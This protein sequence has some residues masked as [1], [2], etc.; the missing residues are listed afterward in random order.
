MDLLDLVP[1]DWWDIDWGTA[2]TWFGAI[3]TFLG[4]IGTV[5]AVVVAL[6]TVKQARDSATRAQETANAALH[7]AR[8]AQKAS[9]E[10]KRKYQA[11]RVSAWHTAHYGGG[12]P[13]YEIKLSNSSP[14]AVYNLTA[15]F[16]WIRGA[17]APRT[18]EE[19]QSRDDPYRMRAL[20][21]VLPQGQFY[22]QVQGPSNNPMNGVLGV[23]VA[24]TDGA[25]LHWI[26]RVPSGDLQ[27]INE[28]ALEHYKVEQP[29]GYN[30]LKV[31]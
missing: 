17:G 7:D 24:F 8:E 12:T 23:E 15:Y 3:A 1:I 29:C 5:G 2:G 21:Q 19:V 30:I 26:R 16:V 31:D 6:S 18:G 4:A 28:G 22:V 9:D 25:G 14:G 10:E 13:T 20:V 27:M 11:S